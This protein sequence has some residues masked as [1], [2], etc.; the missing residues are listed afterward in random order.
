M[1]VSIALSHENI[2]RTVLAESALR[3]HLDA[4][5]PPL[6]TPDQNAAVLQ[7]AA[8]EIARVAMALGAGLTVDGDISALSLEIPSGSSPGA[9]RSMIEQAVGAAVMKHAYA[10]VDSS[11][12]SCFGQLYDSAM[13]CIRFCLAEADRIRPFRY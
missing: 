12:A 5:R 3:H 10:Q 13:E 2:V 1:N 6:L 8:G 7:L 9:L 11:V 4:S